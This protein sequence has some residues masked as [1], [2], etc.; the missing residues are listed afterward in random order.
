MLLIAAAGHG[1]LIWL[2]VALW[3]SQEWRQRQI[4]PLLPLA[5]VGFFLALSILAGMQPVRMP[6]RG[7]ANTTVGFAVDFACLIIFGPVLGS[8]IVVLSDTVLLWRSPWLRRVFN[9]GML[10]LSFTGAC[11]VYQALGGRYVFWDRLLFDRSVPFAKMALP[12]AAGAVA[13]FT[14]P[15]ILVSIAMALWER[16]SAL[17]LWT[18]SFRWVVPRSLALAPFGLLMAMVYQAEGLGLFAVALLLV[19]LIGA[20]FAFKGAMDMLEVHRQTVYALSNAL[21]A[22]DS[23]TRTHSESV[24]RYALQLGTELGLSA[25]RLEV[26]EWA[27]RLHDIGKVH[28]DWDRIIRKPGKPSSQEWEVIRQH[29]VEGGRLAEKMEFLPHTQGEVAKIVRAH[30]ER[31]DGSGYPD[32]YSGN[33]ISL[34]ARILAVADAFEAMTASRAYHRQRSV[35]DAIAELSR[36]A[37]SQFDAQV[38]DALVALAARGEL[39]VAAS[40]QPGAAPAADSVGGKG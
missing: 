35:E 16:R 11:W 2:S 26:L 13:D 28:R 21:W 34:E 15:T 24:T 8:W 39:E 18:I 9:N 37:G 7:G 38:V 31:L 12:L 1:L 20:R 27:G 29:P 10:V 4:A 3:L 22:Y 33:T 36:C 23:Y 30:H 25:A 5:V 19:P 17:G 40:D 6:G 14:F 32:G